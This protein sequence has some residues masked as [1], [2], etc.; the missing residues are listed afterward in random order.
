[1]PGVV[2]TFAS[3]A[4]ADCW[5]T[6]NVYVVVVTPSCAVTIVVKVLLPGTKVTGVD[7]LPEVTAAPLTVMVAVASV[8]V[9]V[10][11]NVVLEAG[12]VSV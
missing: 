11:K 10:T 12:T 3:D 2:V 9:G 8:T 4:M 6:T 1:M 5:S 7:E